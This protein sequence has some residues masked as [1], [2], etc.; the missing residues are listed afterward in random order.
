[1]V[2]RFYDKIKF[3]I[4][5]IVYLFNSS[6]PSYNANSLQVANMCQELSVN[7][8]DVTIITPSNGLKKSISEH[9]GFKKSFNLIRIKRFKTQ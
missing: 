5:K 6:I 9:Y 1:M 8:N 4:M 3:F 2:S 7:G